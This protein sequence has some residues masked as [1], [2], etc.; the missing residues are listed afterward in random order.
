MTSRLNPTPSIWASSSDGT[1]D[2]SVLRASPSLASVDI[3][4][5][6]DTS[7]GTSFLRPSS[8]VSS[9][10]SPLPT[11]R[12]PSFEESVPTYASPSSWSS[13]TSTP[14][15]LSRTVSS[16]GSMRSS[17]FSSGS[18]E[19]LPEVSTTMSLLS[20]GQPSSALSV[21]YSV[22]MDYALLTLSPASST[23]YPTAGFNDTLNPDLGV[24]EC[25]AEHPT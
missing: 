13:G 1:Y 9:T 23:R 10:V 2:S 21:C 15:A 18:L 25:F 22:L 7:F 6:P 16:V 24:N 20:T 12:P 4:Q 17:I 11:P 8:G 19:D 5:A 3:H 14:V